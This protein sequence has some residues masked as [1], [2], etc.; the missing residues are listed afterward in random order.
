LARQHSV[1]S[2]SARASDTTRIIGIIDIIIID[3]TGETR[4]VGDLWTNA[5]TASETRLVDPAL[6]RKFKLV[7][8]TGRREVLFHVAWR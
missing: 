5:S 4:Q 1:R 3:I 6:W 7:C 8:V 2:Q